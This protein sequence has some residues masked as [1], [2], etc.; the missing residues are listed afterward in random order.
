MNPLEF[1][2]AL[3]LGLGRAVL[4]LTNHDAHTYRE[5]ILDACLHNKAYDP[6]VE[7]SRARY[8]MDIILRT[9]DAPFYE[10]A[11]I[12]SLWEGD[13]GWDANQRFGIARL[14][15]QGGNASARE[16]MYSAFRANDLS[17][18]DI[19]AEFIELDGLNGL[20]FVV[21]QIGGRLLKNPDQ[22]EDPG[23]RWVAGE[24]CGKRTVEAALVDAS[25]KDTKVMAYLAAA[26]ENEISRTQARRPD[27]KALTYQQIRSLIETK[28]AGGLLREWATV[29]SDADL[30]QAAHDMIQEKDPEKLRS[31]LMLFRKRSFPLELDHLFRLLELPDGPVPFHALRVLANL[32][33]ESI[34]RLAFDLAKAESRRRGWAIDLLVRNFRDD[35]YLTVEAWCDSEQDSGTVNAFDRSLRDFFSAHPN[36]ETEIRLL[37][38]MYEK[39]P[40]AHCR[41]S[42]VERLL[43]MN[44]LTDALRNECRQDSYA[45]TRALVDAQ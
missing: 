39:E 41:S 12:R 13:Q 40:C 27:P 25:A 38:N 28:R 4:Q 26:K 16:A 15:A 45:D 23:L 11:V 22:W 5:A 8:M 33:H 18:I 34:R 42:V 2:R 29:A 36:P 32:E 31:F 14:L 1:Q 43:E 17:A 6:Q 24:I 30:K 10:D 37:K 9:G 35:D 20:I 44:G 3:T 21:G 7:G 19:A